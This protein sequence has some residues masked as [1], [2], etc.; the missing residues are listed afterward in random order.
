M[1]KA[2]VNGLLFMLFFATGCQEKIIF[3]PIEDDWQA[4]A[5]MVEK[6]VDDETKRELTIHLTP[7]G[8]IETTTL[9]YVLTVDGIGRMEKVIDYDERVEMTALT[10]TD[11]L[12]ATS[13]ALDI[14][15][16][17]LYIEWDD[18]DK[19]ITFLKE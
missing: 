15:H 4:Q 2:Y 19:Q 3:S 17:E 5:V 12:S 18:H 10:I 11:W 1:K 16:F 8:H 6:T 9:S 13:T 7:N 14:D